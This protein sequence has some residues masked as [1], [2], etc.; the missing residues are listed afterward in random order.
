[1]DT[2]KLE[3]LLGKDYSDVIRYTNEAALADAMTHVGN[4]VVPISEHGLEEAEKKA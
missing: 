2:S 3:K 4:N 1:M